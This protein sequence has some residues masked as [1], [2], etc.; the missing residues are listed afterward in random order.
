[1]IIVGQINNITKIRLLS[2]KDG[3]FAKTVLL[4]E[5]QEIRSVQHGRPSLLSIN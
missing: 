3:H 5:E 4:P 2:A 1:M